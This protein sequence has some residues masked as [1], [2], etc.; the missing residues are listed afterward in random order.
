MFEQEP[1]LI[2]ENKAPVVGVTGPSK[3]VALVNSEQALACTKEKSTQEK[4]RIKQN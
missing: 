1:E 2:P 4:V 3:D